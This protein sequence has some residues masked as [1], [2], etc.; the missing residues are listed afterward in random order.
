MLDTP[1]DKDYDFVF[2]NGSFGIGVACSC[3]RANPDSEILVLLHELEYVEAAKSGNFSHF[4]GD[5]EVDIPPNIHFELASNFKGKIRKLAFLA[6]PTKATREAVGNLLNQ[7][8]E[9]FGEN[10]DIVVGSK[11]VELPDEGAVSEKN[12]PCEI[13]ADT[14]YEKTKKY[15]RKR[16]GYLIGGTLATTLATNRLA[17]A[18]IGGE[19]DL[20][21]RVAE[22][23]EGSNLE[24]HFEDVLNKTSLQIGGAIK[25]VFSILT[26]FLQAAIAQ[27]HPMVDESSAGLLHAHCVAE[28]KNLARACG[29]EERALANDGGF[30]SDLILS[31]QGG[32][33]RNFTF[34]NELGKTVS[35]NSK[36]SLNDINSAKGENTVEGFDSASALLQFAKNK[37]VATPLVEAV[38][39]FLEGEITPNQLIKMVFSQ[40]SDLAKLKA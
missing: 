29:A 17:G 14:I 15:F 35:W 28:F 11:G 34:G 26:G 25:N 7:N 18:D 40:P 10:C 9:I 20:K 39:K 5:T 33:T 3:A 36:V 22:H 8:P 1:D 38:T 24:I 27:N 12:L 32:K 37:G 4:F 16:I 23:F 21:I 2:T 30:I 31:M 6:F 19:H 13:V